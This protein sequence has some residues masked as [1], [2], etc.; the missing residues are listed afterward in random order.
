ME[1]EGNG[2][3]TAAEGMKVDVIE[4]IGELYTKGI[5]RLAE[6]QKNGLELAV[7]H[8]AEVASRVEEVLAAD[9]GRVDAGSGHHGV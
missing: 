7:K 1:N 4:S 2:P 6:I 8:N 5:E 3:V 9:A